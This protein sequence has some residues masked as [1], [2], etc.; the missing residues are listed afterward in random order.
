M[1]ATSRKMGYR[2]VSPPGLRL[3]V[4]NKWSVGGT[5]CEEIK[6]DNN[7]GLSKKTEGKGLIN[8][9]IRFV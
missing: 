7:P 2:A 1:Q 6:R 9:L 5:R 3:V 8:Q 4:I